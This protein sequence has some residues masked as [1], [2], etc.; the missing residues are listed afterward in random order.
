MGRCLWCGSWHWLCGGTWI[1]T[2]VQVSH[3]DLL[4]VARVYS[5][6]TLSLSLS[7]HVCL[8][9]PSTFSPSSSPSNSDPHSYDHQMARRH[10]L[11]RWLM[12]ASHDVVR[13]EMDNAGDSVR[14]CMW[15]RRTQ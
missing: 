13:K 10:A 2:A 1:Q 3:R 8:F 5:S 12:D 11:S 15:M 7:L 14:A 9:L 6:L 4:L